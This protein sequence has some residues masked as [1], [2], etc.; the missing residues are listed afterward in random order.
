[1][2]WRDGKY[3]CAQC[4]AALDVA[5]NALP[6]VVIIGASGKRNQRALMLGGKEVHRCEIRDDGR[7]TR[8]VW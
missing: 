1:M 2:R 5:K 8:P 4:G 7:G 3:E 6:L